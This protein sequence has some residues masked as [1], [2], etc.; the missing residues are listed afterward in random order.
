MSGFNSIEDLIRY[1]KSKGTFRVSTRIYTDPKI[2]ELEMEKIFYG[3]WVFLGHESQLKEPND[4]V[5]THIGSVPVIL[6]RTEE[7]EIVG[8]VNRCRHR[9]SVVC[10]TR[11]GN[12]KFFR[13]PYHGWTYS[14]DGRLVGIPDR[15]GYPKTF[16]VEDLNLTRIRIA[17]KYGFIFG[18]LAEDP[19]SIEEHLGSAESFLRVLGNK[20]P[21]GI[22]VLEGYMS[23]K[24]R[25]N[26]KILLEGSVDHYHVPFAHES[27]TEALKNVVG[28]R[29]DLRAMNSVAHIGNGHQVLIVHRETAQFGWEDS[30]YLRESKLTDFEKL[31]DSQN[32]FRI[33]I[34][35]NVI[36]WGPNAP[37]R[38]IQ[39][40]RPISP[41]Y[42][43]LTTYFYLP[44]DGPK[45][46]REYG[47]V[48]KDRWKMINLLH[49]PAGLNQPD[50]QAVWEFSQIGA[51]NSLG[52][53]QYN[54]LSRGL[55]RENEEWRLKRLENF[56]R[57]D[58]IGAGTDDTA[59]RGFYEWWAKLL[60]GKEI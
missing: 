27:T 22:R 56:S 40:I 44:V 52:S 24:I 39:I 6:V 42:S 4:Y 16:D 23:A 31:W 10:L 12:S 46:Y 47:I 49:S 58:R 33:A 3:G 36:I 25:A 26:W 5:T 54:D 20:Y 8:L 21:K 48:K 30:W 38:F 15:E 51:G 17:N 19:P 60:F 2:F 55:H 1:D 57:V 53:N 18:S 45:E 43:E 13:C 32:K 59:I 35:P 11:M 34:F 50:D 41:E 28:R 7:G 37:D 14:N 9:G 29:I